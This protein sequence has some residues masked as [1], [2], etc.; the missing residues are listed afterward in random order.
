MNEL[1]NSYRDYNGILPIR[2]MYGIFTY[3]YRKNQLNVGK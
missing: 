1:L 3:I 2:S